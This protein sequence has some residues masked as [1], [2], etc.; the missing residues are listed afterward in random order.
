MTSTSV[1][2]SHPAAA[3]SIETAMRRT[4]L[5][6]MV[7][8]PYGVDAIW[9]I[10]MV[11]IWSSVP[12]PRA[13]VLAIAY[14]VMAAIRYGFHFLYVR[15]KPADDR[16]KAWLDVYVVISI[17]IGLGWTAQTM[18]LLGTRP[19]FVWVLP[20]VA[21]GVMT[22]NAAYARA[23]YPPVA[24]GF[25]V[26][27]LLPQAIGLALQSDPIARGL[28]IGYLAYLVALTLWTRGVHRRMRERFT[29]EADL[30]QRETELAA[31]KEEAEVS[32]LAAETAQNVMRTVLDAIDD[33]VILI[34]RTGRCRY[35]NRAIRD[36][37]QVDEATLAGLPTIRDIFLYQARRGDYGPLKDPEASMARLE[38]R[39]WRGEAARMGRTV[40]GR[41]LDYKYHPL[42]DGSI[43]MTHRD[44]TELKRHEDELA[45]AM[46]EAER[47]R[48][49]TARALER[50]QVVI[51]N[52]SDGVMLFDR[53]LRW[54][55]DNQKVRDLLA[56]PKEVAHLGAAS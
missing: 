27:A 18:V 41:W 15:R 20:L 24:M 33:G 22:V 44:I 47:A 35:T 10:V 11:S 37:Y 1:S 4:L 34:D 43:V 14:G 42:P 21:L 2:A 19:D 9:L 26:P 29:I 38:E 54:A 39:F 52:M 17:G 36:V 7:S 40:T 8:S 5:D 55:I 49:E 13:L 28:G 16:L 51:D 48:A 6:S 32:R 23:L 3:H 53:D 50:L 46:E 45:A 30:K 31:A 12:E 56:L 25:F